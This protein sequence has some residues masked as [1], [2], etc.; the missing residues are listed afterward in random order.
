MDDDKQAVQLFTADGLVS[1]LVAHSPTSV[2]RV[3]AVSV[4]AD[5]GSLLDIRSVVCVISAVVVLELL[6]L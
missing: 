1:M 6:P 5:A 4:V 2:W 3:L